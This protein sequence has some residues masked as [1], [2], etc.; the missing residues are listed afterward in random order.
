VIVG[1][2]KAG[3]YDGVLG[4]SFSPDGKVLTYLAGI[5]GEWYSKVLINGKEYIGSV[6]NGV[7]V[8]VDNDTIRILNG[9]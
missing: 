3:P 2:D 9:K 4:F 6:S 1:K 8:Y 7:V 5:D